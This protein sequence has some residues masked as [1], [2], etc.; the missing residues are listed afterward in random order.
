M[1]AQALLC[2]PGWSWSR[3]RSQAPESHPYRGLHNIWSSAELN[4]LMAFV[5]SIGSFP[6][7][8]KDQTAVVDNIGEASPLVDGKCPR[9]LM[10][11]NKVN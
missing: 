2:E 11:A 8:S 1:L 10:V 3:L 5:E 6:T 4:K 9:L 7:S